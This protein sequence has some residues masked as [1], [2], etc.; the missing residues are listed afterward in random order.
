MTILF[1][2]SLFFLIY[3]FIGYP[4]FLQLVKPAKPIRLIQDNALPDLTVILCIYNSVELLENKVRNILASNYP[5][6]KLNILI[7]SDGSTDN[8]NLVIKAFN[9]A[10]VE[11]I[12]YGNN[13]GKSYALTYAKKR[14]TTPFAAFTDI[15]QSFDKD[16]LRCLASNLVIASTGAVS[17]NLKIISSSGKEDAG[18][19]WKYEKSIRKKESD[20][21]SLLGVTGAIYMVKTALLP[22]VPEDSLLDDMY[23]PL[24]MVKQ[25]YDIK[26][27]ED[28]IA[29]DTESA[30]LEE[31]FTRK[32]RTLAG[33]Y[34]LM[35]QLPWLLSVRKNPLFFQFFSHKVARLIM[36]F[37]LIALFIASFFLYFP[38]K[39]LITAMQILFYSYSLLGYLV[40]DAAKLPFMGTCVNFCSL[41]LAALIAAWKYF[42]VKDITRLWKKH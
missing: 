39:Q 42:T 36:P 14:I 3:T 2:G 40:K 23:I 12:G 28:A 10:S 29:Y 27:C 5:K 38:E 13:R 16:A 17:G 37:A 19:Y 41:N 25:G 21:K 1:F 26:F 6:D 30:S 18:L 32:V 15:R 9:D 24:T 11:L 4:L 35:K 31:E 33:N 22:D 8:P 20:L 34:Q 7:V